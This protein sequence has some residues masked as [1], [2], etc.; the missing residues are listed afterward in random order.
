MG[1]K[2][3]RH[4]RSPRVKSILH[5]TRSIQGSAFLGLRRLTPPGKP[6]SWQAEAGNRNNH[7]T[8]SPRCL[9]DFNLNIVIE[10]A[11]TAAYVG[12]C[13]LHRIDRIHDMRRLTDP[14]PLVSREHVN[15]Y[16]MYSITQPYRMVLYPQYLLNTDSSIVHPMGKWLLMLQTRLP[17]PPRHV[18]RG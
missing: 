16:R 9:D 18:L 10:V 13:I 1:E 14:G 3:K 17:I 15:R 5:D 7:G 11:Q 12:Q 6:V 2:R 4:E 8:C